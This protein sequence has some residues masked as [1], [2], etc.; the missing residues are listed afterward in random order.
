MDEW[1]GAPV[2]VLTSLDSCVL[3][4]PAGLIECRRNCCD[5]SHT[6]QRSV[7]MT[8]SRCGAQL[9]PWV[10]GLAQ[11]GP[12]RGSI[13]LGKDEVPGCVEH[14]VRQRSGARGVCVGTKICFAAS[15]GEEED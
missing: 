8:A 10:P 6:K 9:V 14:V 12:N 5:F 15:S 13:P 11:V 2:D 3:H 7:A 1:R 4:M